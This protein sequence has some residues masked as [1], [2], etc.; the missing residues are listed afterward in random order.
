MT[1]ALDQRT[2]FVAGGQG[3]AAAGAGAAGGEAAGV[4]LGLVEVAVGAPALVPGA[5]FCA[6]G[7]LAA[8][9]FA[10]PATSNSA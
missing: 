7:R 10:G 3:D 1:A 2:G 8:G 9:F 4:G 6:T 5:G